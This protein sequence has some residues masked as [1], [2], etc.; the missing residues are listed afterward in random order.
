MKLTILGIQLDN[1]AESELL[2][3]IERFLDD[4]KP[5]YIVTPNPEFLVA[6]QK[7]KSFKNILNQADLA[8]PDGFGL[9]LASRLLRN[10]KLHR[11][12]GVDTLIKICKL[13]SQKKKSVYFFGA[14]DG[15]A[16]KTAD[17]LKKQFPKLKIAGAESGGVIRIQASSNSNLK[18]TINSPSPLSNDDNIAKIKE[19]KPDIIFVALGQV[20]QEKWI[21]QKLA[22]IVS[23][24]LAMGVGGSFDYISKKISRAPKFLR[25]LGLE[26]LFRLVLEPKRIKR[27]WNAVVMFMWLVFKE[28][29]RNS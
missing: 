27:V 28:K 26:W 7:D 11:H 4:D 25:I 10:Q 21:S 17:T 22:K 6:A 13:A 16:R 24:R 12:T 2:L 14:G 23:I 19:A 3:K 15:I 1:L 9:K 8:I 20:K 5:H 18:Q 29:I